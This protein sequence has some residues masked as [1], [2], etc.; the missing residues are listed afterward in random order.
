MKNG[1]EDKDKEKK[2]GKE[3]HHRSHRSHRSEDK[4][5]ADTKDKKHH[6]HRHHHG[7]EKSGTASKPTGSAPK[8]PLEE[9]IVADLHTA[10]IPTTAAS[11]TLKAVSPKA[12]AVEASKNIA[13]AQPDALKQTV[14]AERGIFVK[15][16]DWLKS[17][18]LKPTFSRQQQIASAYNLQFLATLTAI[19]KRFSANDETPVK[20]LIAHKSLQFSGKAENITAADTAT[21][22]DHNVNTKPTIH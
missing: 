8:P 18:L 9:R 17:K 21:V 7:V 4:Q 11:A 15:I 19:Q 22:L 10:A 5:K 1:P 16:F 20:K 14:V 3:G 13:P 2:A 12:T 6:H